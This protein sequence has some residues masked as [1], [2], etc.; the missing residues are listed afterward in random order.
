MTHGHYYVTVNL[1][2]GTDVRFSRPCMTPELFGDVGLKA[3]IKS[4]AELDVRSM[5]RRLD[6]F[7][8]STLTFRK[9]N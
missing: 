8:W 1:A 3:A 5:G 7:D 2:D 6:E 9:V 4:A